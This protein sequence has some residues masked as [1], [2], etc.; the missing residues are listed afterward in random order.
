MRRL[1]W[2]AAAIAALGFQTAHAETSGHIDAG[3]DYT[4]GYSS[5]DAFEAYSIGGAVQT[6]MG[7]WMLGLDG[8]TVLQA[9]NHGDGDYS[10]GYAA[11]HADTSMGTWDVGAFIGILNYYGEGGKMVGLETRTSW[12]NF[13]LQGSTAYAA[14]NYNPDY[15]GYDVRLDGRYFFSPN[16]ALTG[17]LGETWFDGAY[18][19][20]AEATDVGIGL[21]YQYA[22][23]LELSG[24]YQSTHFDFD[25]GG[26]NS[27]DSLRIAVSFHLNGGTMQDE[28][29]HGASWTGA[30]DLQD[31]FQRW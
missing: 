14:F 20:D 5:S 17:N 22:N 6:D 31:T 26:D 24:G 13:S 10:H 4:D 12:G 29:N 23:G 1:L 21:A 8:R 25:G 16:F 19:N 28:T 27:V 15:D 9:W 2:G 7:G 3:F 11:L 30:Q 18:G